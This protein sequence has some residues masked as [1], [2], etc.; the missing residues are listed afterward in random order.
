MRVFYS[1]TSH[2]LDCDEK[3]DFFLIQLAVHLFSF[4]I[5]EFLFTLGSFKYLIVLLVQAIALREKEDVTLLE[6][7]LCRPLTEKEKIRI[8]VSKLRTFLEELLQK[9]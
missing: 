9:R 1:C 8:G 6:E 5:G 4:G 7:K 2:S 3:L